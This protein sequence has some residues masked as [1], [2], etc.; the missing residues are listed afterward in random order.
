[1]SRH[2]RRE[3]VSHVPREQADGVNG[4]ARSDRSN[5]LMSTGNSVRIDSV[6]L[7]FRTQTQISSRWKMQGRQ[8]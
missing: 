3:A 8:M 1:M 5:G 7:E 6:D 4:S 2:T